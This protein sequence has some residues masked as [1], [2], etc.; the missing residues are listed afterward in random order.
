M[1]GTMFFG[2]KKFSPRNILFLEKFFSVKLVFLKTK[3]FLE[4]N[5]FWKNLYFWKKILK[6]IFFG[7]IFFWKKIIFGKNFVS[8]NFFW[9][10]I[11]FWTLFFFENLKKKFGK[12]IFEKKLW[13]SYNFSYGTSCPNVKSF[14]LLH[15]SVIILYDTKNDE[16]TTKSQKKGSGYYC[17][18]QTRIF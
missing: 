8:E 12:K 1:F 14:R 6:K 10:K 9:E 3:F 4:K 7:R 5:F 16:K 15:H 13:S 2:K 11:F 17:T 18:A